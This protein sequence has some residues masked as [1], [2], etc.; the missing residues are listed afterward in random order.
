MMQ[1]IQYKIVA[2][3]TD[4]LASLGIAGIYR[5]NVELS[6]IKKVRCRFTGNVIPGSCSI[7]IT[8]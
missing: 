2:R 3:E 5:Y 7:L 4:V 1:I 8:S 6:S